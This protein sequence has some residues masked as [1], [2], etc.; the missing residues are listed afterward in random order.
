MGYC[1]DDGWA[2]TLVAEVNNQLKY[3]YKSYAVDSQGQF[4]TVEVNFQIPQLSPI[5]QMKNI[6]GNGYKYEIIF[7][8][9][10]TVKYA[11]IGHINQQC[12][13]GKRLMP[14]L[15]IEIGSCVKLSHSSIFH[16]KIYKFC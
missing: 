3:T 14:N 15:D 13:D 1:Y 6:P 5:L 8:L 11:Q 7:I 16:T 4:H 10:K 2:V 12:D 9:H